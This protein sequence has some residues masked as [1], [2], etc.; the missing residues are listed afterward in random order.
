MVAL[1]EMLALPIFN[2]GYKSQPGNNDYN[3]WLLIFL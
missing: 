2:L 1:A 3:S